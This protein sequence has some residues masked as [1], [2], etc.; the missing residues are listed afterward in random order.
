MID[1]ARWEARDVSLTIFIV[2]V[3][4]S[5]SLTS[6]TNRFFHFNG[7]PGFRLAFDV[8][9]RNEKIGRVQ[10]QRSKESSNREKRKRQ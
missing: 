7:Y 1:E 2:S 6:F 5:E 10:C 8:A 4:G 9:E 3:S